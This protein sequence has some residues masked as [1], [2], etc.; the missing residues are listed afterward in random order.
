[1]NNHKELDTLFNQHG[2]PD[3]KW[4]KSADIAVR[5]W[6]R[7]KCMFG[8]SEYGQNACC[9]PNVPDVAQC[10]QFFG[11]YDSAV[12]FHF[13]KTVADPNDRHAWSKE[14]N[15]GLLKLERQVFWAGFPKAFMMFMDTCGLCRECPAQRDKCLH[16]ADSRPAPD[17]LA[18]DVFATVRKYG[19][20]INVLS[21]YSQAMNRYAFLMIE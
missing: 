6:V 19:Y 11:E 2:Y 9:P 12:I 10:R 4:I 13:E 3:F 21:D 15:R 5:Q 8:C 17:A 16:A 7:M 18:V 20:P 14:V 1:M